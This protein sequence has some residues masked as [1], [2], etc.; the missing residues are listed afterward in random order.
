M[1]ARLPHFKPAVAAPHCIAVGL[2]RPHLL[3]IVPREEGGENTGIKRTGGL[4]RDREINALKT[5]PDFQRER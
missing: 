1:S 5:V 4:S 3:F 2:D